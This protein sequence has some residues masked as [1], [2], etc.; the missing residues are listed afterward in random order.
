MVL[1]VSE[2]RRKTII[3]TMRCYNDN[4][5]DD[6]DDDGNND[7]SNIYIHGTDCY[8]NRTSY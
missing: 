7:N 1:I 2:M 5:D 3:M 6:N 8:S 4:D